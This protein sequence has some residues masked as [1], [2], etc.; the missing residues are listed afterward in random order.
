MQLALRGEPVAVI[1]SIQS[2]QKLVKPKKSL[3]EL[4]RS[5][6]EN[7]ENLELLVR[8]DTGIRKVTL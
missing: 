7:L 2:Y 5:A 8:K 1:V 3:V 6:P 4:L